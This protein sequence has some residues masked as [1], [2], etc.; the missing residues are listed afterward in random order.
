LNNPAGDSATIETTETD[1]LPDEKVVTTPETKPAA[2][3]AANETDQDT[4]KADKADAATDEEAPK[5]KKSGFQERINQI[6]R[7]MRN[8]ER[9]KAVAEQRAATA[10]RE[11]AELK[12]RGETIDPTDYIAQQAHETRVILKEE[13]LQGERKHVAAAEA[14][15]RAAIAESFDAKVEDALERIPDLPQAIAA[16][17]RMPLSLE[18]AELIAESDKMAE[19]I[20]HLSTRPKDVLA[21]K[22]MT[23]QQMGREIGRLEARVSTPAKKTTNA[24]P[25]THTKVVGG[26]TATVVTDPNKMSQ[27][28]YE[29]WR[30]QAGG[31]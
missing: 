30:S 5:P 31:S 22:N 28:Q 14:E 2:D 27:K 13:A 25:P 7:D 23:P 26:G 9:G 10:E 20:L 21:L 29:A 3:Q 18:A 16:F 19:I 12:K 1:R 24:P 8:A 11:L 4:G 17:D 6:T 15:K